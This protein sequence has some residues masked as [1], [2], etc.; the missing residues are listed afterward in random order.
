MAYLANYQKQLEAA[1]HSLFPMQ[2]APLRS[3]SK[4][5]DSGGYCDK[6]I[7]DDF[8]TDI[9]LKF[10]KATRVEESNEHLRTLTGT[11]SSFQGSS[12]ERDDAAS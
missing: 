2:R 3:F 1:S 11:F 5:D 8:I 12:A 7:T 9:Y 4:P 10:S 6:S